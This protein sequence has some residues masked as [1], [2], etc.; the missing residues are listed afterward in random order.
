MNIKNPKTEILSIDRKEVLLDEFRK[1]ISLEEYYED[2]S[3]KE[4]IIIDNYFTYR[5]F[6]FSGLMPG[7]D[8]NGDVIELDQNT[9]DQI[10]HALY[11]IN[12]VFYDNIELLI[13]KYFED[14]VINVILDI[15]LASQYESVN[16]QCL[17]NICDYLTFNGD[18]KIFCS[19]FFIDKLTGSLFSPVESLMNLSRATL[20]NLLQYED[21]FAR[22]EPEFWFNEYKEIDEDFMKNQN[23]PITNVHFLYS[24]IK[25]YPDDD[26]LLSHI[27]L[28]T[29][30][31]EEYF[32]PGGSVNENV[33]YFCVKI[34]WITL[35]T[36]FSSESEPQFSN[37]QNQFANIQHQISKEQYN[38]KLARILPLFTE[39]LLSNL[40]TFLGIQAYAPTVALI[41]DKLFAYGVEIGPVFQENLHFILRSPVGEDNV[42]V[43]LLNLIRKCII[44]H[45]WYPTD[46]YIQDFLNIADTGKYNERKSAISVLCQLNIES[47]PENDFAYQIFLNMLLSDDTLMLDLI[48]LIRNLLYFHDNFKFYLLNHQD[49]MERLHSLI[50]DPKMIDDVENREISESI[51]IIMKTATNIMNNTED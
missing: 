9:I 33:P 6:L 36:D 47:I 13:E 44:S 34:F 12:Q 39:D 3:Q 23:D 46:D 7:M 30:L 49:E 27:Q 1:D 22:K 2:C 21:F 26:Y 11:V 41:L 31:F 16:T 43:T 8:E 38:S 42:K 19:D 14:D 20:C 15:Y 17:A 45:A 35:S 48:K 40:V 25:R 32:I 24:L 5:D 18:S 4:Q 29:S 28:C 51:D 10:T 37:E 50:L